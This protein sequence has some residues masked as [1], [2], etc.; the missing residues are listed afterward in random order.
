MLVT[1]VTVYGMVL[2]VGDYN[3]SVWDGAGCW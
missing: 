2:G 3:D 1:I